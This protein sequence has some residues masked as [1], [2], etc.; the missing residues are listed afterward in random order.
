M[1]A[2]PSQ[3]FYHV[4]VVVIFLVIISLFVLVVII[5]NNAMALQVKKGRAEAGVAIVRG[6]RGL[7]IFVVDTHK[8]AP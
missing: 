2:R 1:T 7:S 3:R 8:G 5:V 4:V 6:L